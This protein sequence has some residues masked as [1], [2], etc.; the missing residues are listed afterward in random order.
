MNQT[1]DILAIASKIVLIV[2]AL[3]WGLVGAFDFNLVQYIFSP[4]TF[5]EKIIYGT[6]GLAGLFTLY[7]MIKLEGRA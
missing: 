1:Q 4:Y 2:G 3:N 5:L 7:R 6:V